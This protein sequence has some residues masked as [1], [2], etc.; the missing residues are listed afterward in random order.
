ML[1]LLVTE[2]LAELI[3]MHYEQPKKADSALEIFESIQAD[4]GKY[5]FTDFKAAVDDALSGKVT[6]PPRVKRRV[7]LYLRYLFPPPAA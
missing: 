1:R 3:D 4:E 2:L 7:D 6:P 5:V